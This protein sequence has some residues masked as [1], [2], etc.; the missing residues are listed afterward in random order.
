MK[1]QVQAIYENGL[2][3]LLERL[4]LPEGTRLTVTI[5]V[6]VN[7]GTRRFLFPTRLQPLSLLEPLIGAMS[8]GG[9]ALE[10]TEA[11]YDESGFRS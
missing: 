6:P 1:P 7:E 3:R 9:D 2:L 11:L 5:S 8:A 4:D 10:D